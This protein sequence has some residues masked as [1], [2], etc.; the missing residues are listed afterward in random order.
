MNI[1][2]FKFLLIVSI[3]VMPVFL[4]GQAEVANP[5]T[6]IP[7][8]E[9]NVNQADRQIIPQKY[10]TVDVDL[11]KMSSVLDQAPMEF[12]PAAGNPVI[13]KLPMPDGSFQRFEIVESPIMEPGLAA[14]FPEIKTY[15]GKGIDDPG[16]T[17]RMDK[18][19]KGFHAIIL[20]K[21]GSVYIDPYS[22]QDIDHYISYYE[23]DFQR[24]EHLEDFTC[25]VEGKDFGID[26]GNPVNVIES[27]GN[28][29]RTYRLAVATTGEYTAYHG[30]T[31]PGGLSAVVTSINRVNGIYEREV[32]IRF[33]LIANN[34]LIIYTDAQTDPYTNANNFT[35]L[36]QNQSN[37]SSVIGLAN[38]DVGHVFG[39][40]GGGVAFL[41]T[42]C[43]SSFKAQGASSNP[44]PIGNPFNVRVLSHELGHQCGA[45][46]TFNGNSGGCVGNGNPG[47]AYEIG[48]GSTIM[49]YSTVCGAHN[50]VNSTDD[51]FHTNSYE[52]ITDY[53]INGFGNTCAVVQA[54][55]NTPPVANAGQGGFAIPVGTPF[56]LTGVGTDADG[57]SLT[58]CWEQYD[59]GPAGSPANPVGTAPLF[60]S[61]PASS[62]PSRIFPNI[63]TIVNNN[64]SVVEH[65]P[66]ITR[67]LTFRLTVR[68]NRSGG[69]GVDFDQIAFTSTDQAGPFLV[70]HPNINTPVW[71]AGTW[72]DITWN[73]ANTD[74]APVNCAIV[75]I[76]L[77]TDGGFTYPITLAENVLN[78]GHTT[79]MV[80]SVPG[81]LNRIKVEAADNIFFDISNENFEIKLPD[82]PGF[83]YYLPTDTLKVCAPDEA[84]FQLVTSSLSGFTG[85]IS[86]N[87]SNVPAG[88]T[89]SFT[90]NIVSEADT[91]LL[92]ISNTAAITPG[93][94][95][96]DITGIA[97]TG[98]TETVTITLEV[99]S[100]APGEV[101][102]GS[103]LDGATGVPTTP[104][105]FWAPFPGDLDYR[106]EIANNPS[107]VGG[108][109]LISS[110]QKTNSFTPATGLNQGAVYYWRVVAGNIC[111]LG[112]KAFIR[113][114]QTSA[115]GGT[116]TPVIINDLGL[117]VLKWKED[118]ITSSI[119]QVSEGSTPATGIV[120]T[121]VS[122][123]SHGA[124]KLT[125]SV[126]GVGNVFSQDDINNGKL[127]YQHNG[128]NATADFFTYTVTTTSGGY[129]GTLTFSIAI[130]QTTD[131]K[132]QLPGV[133]LQVFPNPATDQLQVVLEGEVGK[134]LNMSIL[135]LHGQR[136]FTD[137]ISAMGGK[138]SESINVSSLAA[139]IYFLQIRTERGQLTRKIEIE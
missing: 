133:E 70:T 50:I 109:V 68:D 130:T 125:N 61:L 96:I 24:P 32:S 85:Q 4:M 31:V 25:E 39:T 19:E 53:T 52:S 111:G 137:R 107:F 138:V 113:S 78:T 82:N 121:L 8:T 102:L 1:T 57:D 60:R 21:K 40:A 97:T 7:E 26:D 106:I 122:L 45:N 117:T 89:V 6:D 108:S 65:L 69:G 67:P 94:Y 59:L 58:Y 114:F 18:T 87:T 64:T 37:L 103:P 12:T 81:F 66:S 20:S 127:T 5:W 95:N 93:V 139:G 75:N 126:L 28:Q 30:G 104:Q 135:N 90:D 62:N 36:G 88:A 47:T 11:T 74:I 13:M 124:V 41:G 131:I 86:L 33:I 71:T 134:I 99:Q 49:S 91:T 98:E 116:P 54:T 83:A 101:I 23:K 44:T 56:T 100:E 16:A 55:G 43:N 132:D 119:L 9:L 46:H 80:P 118:F 3:G 27:S 92:T 123:P 110:T 73:V 72:Q 76:K 84:V 51:Y 34:N 48:G 22:K 128:D 38:F 15:A 115:S 112:E 29:L 42:V 120:Y 129:L 77:S 136:V 105:F 17:I 63:S 35:M 79:V 2:P 10:R 14:K